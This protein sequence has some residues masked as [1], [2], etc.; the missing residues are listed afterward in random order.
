MSR[1]VQGTFLA[2]HATMHT[3][4]S[5][6]VRKQTCETREEVLTGVEGGGG[7][8]LGQVQQGGEGAREPR[9]SLQVVVAD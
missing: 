5:R 3:C 1:L 4:M 6:L 7:G 9:L 2:S 8:L